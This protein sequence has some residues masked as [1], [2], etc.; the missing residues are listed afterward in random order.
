M[1]VAASELTRWHR[2]LCWPTDQIGLSGD[3]SEDRAAAERQLGEWREAGVT[4]VMDVRGEWNDQDLVAEIAP[5]L[6]YAWL[7]THDSGGAQ[8]D[9]WFEAGV[10]A[11]R[12][13]MGDPRAR[14]LVH[15]HMGVNRG[16]SMG[17]RI[18]LD[19]GW[20]VVDAMGRIRT[21]RPF[22]AMAYA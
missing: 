17:L 11:A 12:P 1:T 7:G 13:I 20:D 21:T 3:L 22:A 16:P 4:H 8:S 14:L 6:G 15:C 2:R 5:E 9:D 10:V 18:M 19:R